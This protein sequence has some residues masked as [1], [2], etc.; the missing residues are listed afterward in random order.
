VIWKYF[1]VRYHRDHV[2]RLMHQVGWSHQKPETRARERDEARIEAWKHR[3]WP[4]VKKTLRGWGPTSSS[5][6]KRAS[7]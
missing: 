2:G 7:S 6:T 1:G 5:P 4:R 3:D